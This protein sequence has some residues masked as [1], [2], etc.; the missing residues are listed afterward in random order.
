MSAGPT[1][2]GQ[3]LSSE[4]SWRRRL[5]LRSPAILAAVIYTGLSIAA[6]LVFLALTIAFGDYD[7]VAR[8]GGTIWVFALCMIILMPTVT[9]WVR[10]RTKN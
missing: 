3:G 6:G 7:W 8:V 9:P 4:P 1:S 5:S 2:V 10:D